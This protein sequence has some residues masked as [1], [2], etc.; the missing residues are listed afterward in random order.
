MDF[1]RECH[2]LGFE[3]TPFHYVQ[4]LHTR[5]WK[6]GQK[7][8]SSHPLDRLFEADYMGNS[9]FEWG[10]YGAAYRQMRSCKLVPKSFEVEHEGVTRTV[11]L[12]ASREIADA[13]QKLL[14]LWLAEGCR[15]V[16]P[17]LFKSIFMRE[18]EDKTLPSYYNQYDA[19]IEVVSTW[20]KPNR[21][22]VYYDDRL[23]AWLDIRYGIA[24]T[25]NPVVANMLMTAFGLDPYK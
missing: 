6:E 7:E 17:S 8:Y 16:E 25:L 18:Y 15:G 11:Y 3:S 1:Y 20:E 13:A 22:P 5:I 12:L 19:L 24:W 23:L 21:L 10:A 2:R 4:R 9:D 14:P